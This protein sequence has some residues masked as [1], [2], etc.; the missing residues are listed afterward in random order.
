MRPPA[1]PTRPPPEER[2]RTTG[3]AGRTRGETGAMW[4]R[5]GAATSGAPLGAPGRTGAP[6]LPIN[7]GPRTYVPS[8]VSSTLSLS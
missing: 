4:E 5:G 8:G 2:A 7:L 1:R 6:A 3:G